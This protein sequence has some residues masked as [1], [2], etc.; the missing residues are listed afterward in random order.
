MPVI[1]LSKYEDHLREAQQRI[2]TV[3]RFEEADRVPVQITEAGSFY[4]SMLGVD[5]RD[6]YTDLETQIDVQVRGLKWRLEELRDDRP[7]ASLSMDLGP[8][9][10]AI[11][12]DLEIEF[13]SGTSPWI[14]RPLK[15]P[16]DIRAWNP[17]DPEENPRVEWFFRRFEKFKSI[18]DKKDIGVPITQ[19]RLGIH[20]PLSAACAIMEPADFYV[21]MIEDPETADLLFKKLF[22]FYCRLVDWQDERFGTRTTTL[23]L[24]DDNSCAIS[25]DLYRRMVL[26]YNLALYERYGAEG[27]YL[28]ADGPNDQHFKTYV[29]IIKLDAMDI[30]GF[31]DLRAAVRD[32]KGKV[33]IYG[34]LNNRD[35][36]GPLDDN[37]KAIVDDQLQV[38]GPGGG[39]VLAVG[40]ETYAGVPPQTLVDLVKYAK[41]RGR[42]G[43][44][45]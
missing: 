44:R 11:A 10:E 37:A 1:D 16:E 29:E 12:F 33:V 9:G 21:L 27:R 23:G 31:S 38:A 43:S 3:S 36:Y 24:C 30:G 34:A 6:Y 2:D 32:M 17:P 40:G 28:H 7:L 42:V 45:R 22:R 39:Y 18:A 35:F 19:A 13:P 5:I 20:P 26:Q 4:S 14:A 8:V 15:T 41:E 25:D